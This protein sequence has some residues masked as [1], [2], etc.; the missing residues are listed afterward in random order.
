M[1]KIKKNKVIGSILQV[2]K[3]VVDQS[4]NY[5]DYIIKQNNSL[6]TKQ[7]PLLLKHSRMK[8]LVLSKPKIRENELIYQSTKNSSPKEIQSEMNSDNEEYNSPLDSIRA[9]KTRPNNLPSLCTIFN[10]R[11]SLIRSISSPRKNFYRNTIYNNMNLIYNLPST[12]DIKRNS[13]KIFKG[14]KLKIKNILKNKSLKNNLELNYNNL[15]NKYLNEP[16]YNNLKY[17]E[18]IIFGQKKL[19]EEIIRK[20]LIEFQIEYNKNLTIKKEKIYR[21]G[22]RKKKVYLTLD[23]LKI[24]LNEVKDESSEKIEVYEKPS[25]EY[26]FPF[27][28]LPLFYYKNIESFLS[29]LT[30]LLIWD[31]ERQKFSMTKKDD[32]IIANILRNYEDYNL[33]E[34]DKSVIGSIIDEK[35]IYDNNLNVNDLVFDKKACTIGRNNNILN[36]INKCTS[37]LTNTFNA[38]HMNLL[39]RNSISESKE[40]KE[41]I[42][43]L[44]YKK[45][46]KTKCYDIYPIIKNNNHLNISTFE[47]FWL[48]PKKSFILTIETPLITVNIPSHNLVAKKFIDFEL[49]MFIYSKNFIMW[50]FYIINNLLTYKNFRNL[51]DS[52]Y[53]IPEKRNEFFYI[54]EPKHRR[55]LFTFYELTSL[56]SKQDQKINTSKMTTD[57]K[58]NIDVKE[59][60][61]LPPLLE[62]EEENEKEKENEME[63]EKE[64]EKEKTIQELYYKIEDS[65]KKEENKN[66]IKNENNININSN[67]KQNNNINYS[68]SLFIQKGLLAIAS[69]IDVEKK[70]CNEYTYHF[71]LDQLRKFQIMEM[72]LNK[73]SLFVKFLNI[74]YEKETLSFDFNSFNE[75]NEFN[76]IKDINK[77]NL[78]YKGVNIHPNNDNRQSNNVTEPK[79]IEEFPGKIK[80]TKIRIEIKCPLIL[81]KT[82]DENGYLTT[83]TV[84]V[85]YRVEKI[86][87][88]I[89]IHNSIDLTRQLINILKD[90][91]FCRKVYVSRRYFNKKRMTRKKK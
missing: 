72:F 67:N 27:A 83:E 22:L 59:K 21:Y 11:G 13:T 85:D 84:N 89:I 1:K 71:N 49:M 66:N 73:L 26:I 68:N 63:K 61:E 91:N 41:N 80:G 35:E 16:E 88:K 52:L 4:Q 64:K 74:N 69:F 9:K 25:I 2:T 32:E 24:R 17:D 8:S 39:N 81:M 40:S 42:L 53:S 47:Y 78:N 86:L 14:Q 75:F 15:K 45:N 70:I 7:L 12:L 62:K 55:N 87:S 46:F 60:N 56:F 36:D 6:Y 58:T 33:N 76:W 10:S 77:Y 48:T 43:Y 57:G 38:L 82:L 31:E 23:S 30:K 90:N 44:E 20:K 54:V 19:Y 79:M 37:S 50:D 51:L 65:N 5:Y 34:N 29:V 18:S 3:N 28:L